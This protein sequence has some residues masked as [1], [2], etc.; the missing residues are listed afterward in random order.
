MQ[1]VHVSRFVKIC[2]ILISVT[3]FTL[4]ATSCSG[5][6]RTE[7]TKKGQTGSQLF[8][9]GDFKRAVPK[10]ESEVKDDPKDAALQSQLGRAYEATGELDKAVKAYEESLRLDAKQPEVLYKLA[11]VH[12]AQAQPKKAIAELKK[13]IKLN[14]DFVGARLA[15]GDIYL[16]EGDNEEAAKQY[17]VVLDLKPFGVNLKEVGNKLKKARR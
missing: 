10:L 6:K 12:K 5:E 14:K 1:I 2:L 11:I 9:K 16:E 13:A 15:L 7:T 8:S 4:A 17:E 3:V